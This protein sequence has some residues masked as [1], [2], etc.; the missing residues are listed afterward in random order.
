MPIVL[1]LVLGTVYH[2]TAF[3]TIHRTIT[4]VTHCSCSPLLA[5]ITC[6]L[7]NIESIPLM[8]STFSFTVTFP[9]TVDTK[10]FL[11]VL[12]IS[13]CKEK[14]TL[15]TEIEACAK[16]NPLEMRCSACS[17]HTLAD[18]YSKEHDVVEVHERVS[19]VLGLR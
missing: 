14:V 13:S 1:S 9:M 4:C 11:T 5:N 17:F 2:I 16:R 12:A 18:V 15:G 7:R 19:Q 6:L 3:L 8:K 10:V